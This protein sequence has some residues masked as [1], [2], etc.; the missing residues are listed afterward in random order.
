MDEPSVKKLIEKTLEAAILKL[1]DKNF[2]DNLVLNLEAK[3]NGKIMKHIKEVT[4]PLSRKIEELEAK[5]E[6]ELD[7][8]L[9]ELISEKVNSENE[10]L[11]SRI[12]SL[13]LKIDLYESHMKKIEVK[14]DDAE[15]YSRRACLRIYGIPS[16]KDETAQACTEKV[17]DLFKEIKVPITEE[18]IDRAHRIGRRVQETDG[19]F[20]Q[21]IIVKFHS[22]K[23]RTAVYKERKKVRRKKTYIQLDLTA[24]RAKLLSDAKNK[25]N[26][27]PEV[28]F[29]FVDVNC[30]IGLKVSNGARALRFFNNLEDLEKLIHEITK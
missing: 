16:E 9:N 22:W 21:A 8:K 4:E 6:N 1:P 30:R 20:S 28:D 17:L 19:S 26:D 18:E 13:E 11:S 3:I 12:K 5:F 14:M 25:V 7:T 2:M 27:I 23:L 24:R 29:V 15:Q 10:L